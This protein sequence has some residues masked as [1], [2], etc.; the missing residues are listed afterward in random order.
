MGKPIFLYCFPIVTLYVIC[1]GCAKR[2]TT[3]KGSAKKTLGSLAVALFLLFLMGIFYV[4]ISNIKPLVPLYSREVYDGLLLRADTLLL[5]GFDWP[6]RICRFHNP[7]LN[8][9]FNISY[10]S[11]FPMFGVTISFLAYTK[12]IS[13][14]R[15]FILSLMIV[16]LIG[17]LW[18]FLM[19]SMGDVYINPARYAD[20]SGVYVRNIQDFLYNKHLEILSAP[21]SF[22]TAPFIGIA[23]I[24]SVHIANFLIFMFAIRGYSRL[25][26]AVYSVVFIGLFCSTLYFG[27]HYIIDNIAG[28]VM[29]SAVYFYVGKY[30]ERHS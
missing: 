28:A 27:W 22:R 14:M 6:A 29:A 9:I 20:I 2:Y 30:T 10:L 7:F 13:A 1:S 24:P 12:N 21:G 19:P 25:L 8:K 15:K 5:G 11:L 16:T 17:N 4:G 26:S 23:A 3:N 18:H